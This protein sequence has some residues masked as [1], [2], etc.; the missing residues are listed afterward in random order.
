[1]KQFLN[2]Q[3]TDLFISMQMQIQN[4]DAVTLI[5]VNGNNFSPTNKLDLELPLL[6][7]ID[8][9][10]KHRGSYVSSL[11]FDGWQSRPEYGIETPGI[12]IFTTSQQLFYHWHHQVTGQGWL[13][14][15]F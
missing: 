8:I 14:K 15:P 6:Q 11:I 5:T 1:M 10:V 3:A 13:L 12:W 2:L 7:P 4:S 9:T